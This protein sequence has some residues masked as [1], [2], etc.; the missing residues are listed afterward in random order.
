MS[1]INDGGSAFP[2]TATA[3]TV[4]KQNDGDLVLTNYGSS[5][6]MTLRVWLA[7]KALQGWAAGR[8]HSMTEASDHDTVANACLQY[9]DA[10]IRAAKEE[11]K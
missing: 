5:P 11:S 4:S 6:G 10:I 1:E 7:G 9:A 2:T 3:T 8:N